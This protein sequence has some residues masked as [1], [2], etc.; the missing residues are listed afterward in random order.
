MLATCMVLA[1]M[2]VITGCASPAQEHV[3]K[4]NAYLKQGQYDEAAMEYSK[5][6]ELDPQLAGGYNGLGLAYQKK[7]QFEE[8]IA[9]FDKAIELEPKNAEL[10]YNRGNV[11]LE[12][13]N[14]KQR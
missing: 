14:F 2:L 6:V 8:A 5:A 11:Y 12:R 4:G 7:G 1:T 3:N 10:H 9:D 13:D